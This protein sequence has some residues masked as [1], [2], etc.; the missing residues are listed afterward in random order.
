MVLLPKLKK[1]A[2]AFR[3]VVLEVTTSNEPIDLVEAGYDAGIHI[4]E[5]IQRDMIA[6]RV[7]EDLR[8]AVVGSPE[9]F[10]HRNVP[11]TPHE[12]KEHCCIG[13]RFGGEIYRW[14]FEKGRK[15]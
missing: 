15:L 3:D 5:L 2:N 7:S 10:K 14:E 8:L 9:Y 4:G 11:R 6:V 13:F 12:L 1:F